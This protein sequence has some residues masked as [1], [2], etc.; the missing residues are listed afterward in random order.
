MNIERAVCAPAMSDLET[1]LRQIIAEVVREELQAILGRRGAQV[2]S[3]GGRRYVSPA[4]AAAIASVSPRTIHTW[5][6]QGWLCPCRARQRP[7]VNGRDLP[8]TRQRPRVVLQSEAGIQCQLVNEVAAWSAVRQIIDACPLPGEPSWRAVEGLV[9][10]AVPLVRPL[11]D[12]VAKLR[13]QWDERLDDLGGDPSRLDWGSFR[14]LRLSREEDWSDW[15]AH[16]FATAATGDFAHHLFGHT[17]EG[18]PA[19]LLPPDLGDFAKPEVKREQR[20][21]GD[22]RADLVIRWNDR[23]ITHIEVKVGDEKF[24]KTYPTARELRASAP[25]STWA[26][27]VLIPEGSMDAWLECK[28]ATEGDGQRRGDIRIMTLTWKDV[29]VSLRRSLVRRSSDIVWR[30]WAYAFCGA[31]EAT[32]LGIPRR[33]Q[34]GSRLCVDDLGWLLLCEDLLTRG[35]AE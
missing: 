20:T 24:A 21:D 1:A 8:A 29:G 4:Q 33:R 31:V 18:M 27:F 9:T 23:F 30:S 5:V 14:P 25:A 22:H 26:D 10:A 17:A 35:Q 7:H 32:V 16:L 11:G 12:H 13:K 2:E 6:R 28:T 3:D 15:L 34:T 19:G